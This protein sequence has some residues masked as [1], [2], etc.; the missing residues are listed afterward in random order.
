ME[1]E[2][3]LIKWLRSTSTEVSNI[4]GELI[5]IFGEQYVLIVILAFIYFV[6]N[7]KVGE[8]IAYCVFIG[9]CSNNAIKGLVER[10]R[11]FTVDESI[12]PARQ[13]TA[14]GFSF[15]SGHTQN[16]S[17]FYS[18]VGLHFKNHKLWIAIGVII[19]L[20]AC[21]RVYL[22][23]HYPTD[24]I[25]GALLG[26]GGALLGTY[27]YQKWGS[28]FKHK[29]ILFNATALCFLPFVF[30]YYRPSFS[31]IEIYR[32]FYTGYALFLGFIAAVFVENKYVNFT[33]QTAIKRRL[34]RFGLSLIVF[35]GLLFGLDI[36][37]PEGY[38][39]LDM[40]RYG[41]VSFVGMG[42]FPFLF[43]PLHLD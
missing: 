20:I 22:G 26:F 24:V 8:Q 19:I 7:K 4:I 37:F 10:A 36:L 9:V 32:D 29:M 6:Y 38:I 2:L 16:A 1:W 18:A 13:E 21:S 30:I 41:L 28:N 3:A 34:I 33:C 5:T 35:I 15:P 40:L 39:F 12:I 17:T 11:P 27:L 42:L 43:K 14:T 31:D 25:A 23:V